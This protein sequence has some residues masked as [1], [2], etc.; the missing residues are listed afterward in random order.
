MQ[1][2]VSGLVE[3]VASWTDGLNCCIRISRFIQSKLGSKEAGFEGPTIPKYIAIFISLE[4]NYN[5]LELKI[6]INI[7]KTI[8]YEIIVKFRLPLLIKYA[9]PYKQI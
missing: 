4:L 3:Q 8:W 7:L 6:P 9:A 2:T 1:T 5:L